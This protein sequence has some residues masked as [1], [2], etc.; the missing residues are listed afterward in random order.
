MSLQEWQNN[1]WLRS[2]ITS[3]NEIANLFAIVE[4]DIEDATSDEISDDWKFGIAYNAALKLATIMLY[5]AGFRP[6][7]I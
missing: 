3:K 6:E 1:G 5:V 2:H 7:K 4:R